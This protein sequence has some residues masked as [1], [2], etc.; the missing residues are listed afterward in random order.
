MSKKPPS[1]EGSQTFIG[2]LDEFRWRLIVCLT[3]VAVFSVI[4]YFYSDPLL[5]FI[6]SPI[7]LRVPEIYFFSPAEAFV[8]KVKTALLGGF[9]AASPVI[10]TQL[11]LF[12]SPGLYG[13][14]KKAVFPLVFI[15]SFL[16][17]TGSAFCFFKVMPAALDFL[18]S[19]QTDFY[20]PMVSMTEYV[21]FLSGMLFAFGVAFNLPVFVLAAV[22]SGALSV[23][24]LNT[25]QRHVIVLL[26]IV[27]AV[28]T[29][30]PDI[31]SQFMLAV[32]LVLLFEISV[33]VAV[34]VEAARQRKRKLA[35]E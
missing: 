16:F 28:L 8:V 27:S 10:L 1:S 19:M 35:H 11:W 25:Y 23:K 13:N 18:L 24:T 3:T 20:K 12:V 26:F 9:L 31:A 5:R 15:T 29:P 34:L 2:H 7:R 14:E 22:A 32:P 30:S 33:G 17:L 4:C 21:S 6:T